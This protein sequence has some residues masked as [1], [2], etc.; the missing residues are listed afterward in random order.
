MDVA[1]GIRADGLKKNIGRALSGTIILAAASNYP[2]NN[3]ERWPTAL[4]DFNV[5]Q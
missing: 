2:S 5:P 1:I 3:F 4:W